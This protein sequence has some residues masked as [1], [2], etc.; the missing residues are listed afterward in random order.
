[1]PDARGLVATG[2]GPVLFEFH[3]YSV[4]P[5]PG[6]NMRTVT[7]SVVFRTESP[8]HRWLN[9]AIVVHDGTI[10]FTTMTTE[11]P[12]YICVPTTLA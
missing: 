11:F 4:S 7:A 9:T 2:D 1:M 10:D 8:S 12:T 6:A 5:S 3:G